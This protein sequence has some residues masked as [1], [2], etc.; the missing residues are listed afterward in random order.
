[1]AFRPFG[2]EAKYKD[3]FTEYMKE[4]WKI[5]YREKQISSGSVLIGGIISNISS[6][7]L[8]YCSA[9]LIWNQSFTLGS[10]AAFMSYISQLTREVNRILNLNM[11]SQNV[12][13]SIQRIQEMENLPSENYQFPAQSQLCHI[14][15]IK[16]KYLSF[17]YHPKRTILEDITMEIS[18]PGL[19]TIV[20]K[21]GSGKSTLLKL[22]AG[23]YDSY[24]GQILI[25]GRD[26]QSIPL[27]ELRESVKYISGLPYI[28]NM[29]FYDN[30]RFFYEDIDDSRIRKTYQQAGLSDYI[31]SLPDGYHTLVGANGITLSNG[32]RQKLNIARILVSEAPIL[33]FDEI[34]SELDGSSEAEINL[35]L[36]ELARSRIIIHATHRIASAQMGRQIFVM[37]NGKII[38]DGTHEYLLKYSDLYKN[39]F[40][41]QNQ[42]AAINC[43]SGKEVNHVRK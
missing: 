25:D 30:I 2:I 19:Y 9:G 35:I 24:T 1:M 33:L 40:V 28:E 27:N 29:S 20:G 37:E 8:L 14:N 12:M 6:F 10:M 34:T 7:T 3:R 39:L 38:I 15:E 42:E 17:F 13:V 41:Q 4:Q 5:T 32:Q 21:N 18:V 23:Y 22:L 36:L 31:E 43:L 26:L 11:E 16:T